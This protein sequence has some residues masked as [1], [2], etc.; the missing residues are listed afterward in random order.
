MDTQEYANRIRAHWPEAL[1][2]QITQAM[3]RKTRS[4]AHVTTNTGVDLP[5]PADYA[6]AVAAGKALFGHNHPQE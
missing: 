3:E 4:A 1:H 5:P 2:A 6:V